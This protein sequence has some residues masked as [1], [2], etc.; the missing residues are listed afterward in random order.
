MP[1]SL[2]LFFVVS[3]WGASL[4]GEA[5]AATLSCK[6]WKDNTVLQTCPVD[7]SDPKK[8]CTVSI[9]KSLQGT[10]AANMLGG[11]QIVACG[12]HD[13]TLSATDVI[14]VA[15]ARSTGAN[16]LTPKGYLSGGSAIATSIQAFGITLVEKKGAPTYSGGCGP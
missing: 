7:T 10:C 11:S 16:L 9:S 14:E 15:S 3:I 2:F 6:F 8:T 5:R 12:F 4:S 1:R 13:P